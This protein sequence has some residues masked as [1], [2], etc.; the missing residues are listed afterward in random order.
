MAEN[1]ETYAIQQF[2]KY[3]KID[4]QSNPETHV[5]P[6]TQCQFDMQRALQS[7]LKA[8]G[9]ESTIN[10]EYCLLTAEI[11]AT[12]NSTKSIGFL[13]HVDTS[14]DAPGTNVKPMIHQL[15]EIVTEDLQ[16]PYETVISKEDLKKYAGKKII[17]SSGDTLLGADD[18]GGVAMIMGLLHKIVTENIPHP[19]I[20]IIFTPDEEIGESSDNINVKELGLDCA[21][22][23]DGDEFQT[24]YEDG[25]NAYSAEL[26]IIGNET[27]PG[28]AFG[29]LEDAGYIL[30]EFNMS[31][32]PSRRPET[33]KEDQ[34][35]ILCIKSNTTYSQAEAQYILRSFKVEEMEYFIQLMKDEVE[36]LKRKYTKSKFEITFREQY[37]N[38]KR[39]MSDDTV[40][41]NF[42]KA[43]KKC[44]LTP[45][46][47][48]MRGGSDASHLCEKG[49]PTITT[50]AGGL[51]FHSK[52]EFI[53]VEAINVGVDVLCE[54][55]QLF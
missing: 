49:L 46:K 12:N 5:T 2:I 55:V 48:F 18:K 44:N 50:F 47:K 39:Y 38:P 3:C 32:P 15:P 24:Y 28:D 1:T 37:Q 11:P 13:A 14:A 43:M 27:H 53:P 8:L 21:Y 29:K 42:V 35:Y 41:Q 25:F 30:S 7:D 17:T 34:G 10:E 22:V 19:K 20:K 9:I 31:L 52:R 26:K 16:L 45:I 6:S 40:V 36:R 23:I 51:N 33:T 4:S 54:L